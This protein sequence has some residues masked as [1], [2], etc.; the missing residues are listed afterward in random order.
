[1]RDPNFQRVD[2]KEIR[3]PGAEEA[4]KDI[5]RDTKAF[6]ASI[7]NRV[8]TFLRGLV[9]GDFT[10]AIAHLSSPNDLD[11]QPWTPERLQQA[12]DAFYA[13]HERVC[14]DPNAR[15][16]RHTYVTAAE[17]KKS[18]IVQQMLVDPEGHNDWVAEFAVDLAESRKS[19]EPH[20]VLRRIGSLTG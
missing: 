4:D 2:A 3:P 19:E 13:E 9:I 17:N 12:L 11:G 10:E 7:R 8:F 20:L 16:A 6:T 14:L 15:N 1:M 18:W 5:T